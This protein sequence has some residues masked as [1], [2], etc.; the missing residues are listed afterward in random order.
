MGFFE[1]FFNMT[2]DEISKCNMF[3]LKL[4]LFII[5]IIIVLSCISC[6]LNFYRFEN[7]SNYS[8]YSDL[9]SL[10][11][12]K[13]NKENNNYFQS[14]EL[15]NDNSLIFGKANIL[16][17]NRND[18]KYMKKQS[19][20]FHLDVFCNLYV[21]NGNPFSNDTTA[22]L[23]QNLKFDGEYLVYLVDSNNNKLF[24]DKMIKKS[25]GIYRLNYIT[26]FDEKLLNYNKIIIVYKNKNKEESILFGNFF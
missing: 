20:M 10:K 11:E 26:K 18:Y 12:N 2:Y 8:D 5:L 21:L 16:I 14:A 1:S 4:S 6:I 19:P 25:D 17:E 23:N 3:N 22:G 9:F 13:Q 7:Y 15:T 24:I